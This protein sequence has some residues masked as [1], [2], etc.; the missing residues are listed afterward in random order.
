[1]HGALRILFVLNINVYL[2]ITKTLLSLSQPERN[3]GTL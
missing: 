3:E 1:M 2:P